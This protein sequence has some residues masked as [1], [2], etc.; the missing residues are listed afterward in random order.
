MYVLGFFPVLT[1]GVREV[2]E[3]GGGKGVSSFLLQT[4]KITRHG[5]EE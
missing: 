2:K 1:S 4:A 3:G 5:E